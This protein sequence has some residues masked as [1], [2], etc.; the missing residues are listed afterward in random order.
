MRHRNA[1][2]ALIAIV[3]VAC[4]GRGTL[5]RTDPTCGPGTHVE[6][7]SCVPDGT[8]DTDSS[9]DTDGGGSSDTDAGG[10]SDTDP[11]TLRYDV[12]DDGVA[13]FTTL[14]DA[15]DAA[16]DG[17]VIT[18]CPGRWY[19]GTLERRDLTIEGIDG[20][21]QTII[22]GSATAAALT[23]VDSTLKVRGLTLTNRSVHSS[24]PTCLSAQGS[25]ISGEDLVLT[26]VQAVTVDSAYLLKLNDTESTWEN[27]RVHDNAMAGTLVV[28]NGGSF[29]L[30]H[31]IFEH[32][33]SPASGGSFSDLSALA[34][35]TVSGEITNNLFYGNVTTG[36]HTDEWFKL[37]AKTG[38]LLLVSNNVFHENTAP[39]TCALATIDQFVDFRNNIVSRNCGPVRGET[40]AASI[41]YTLNFQNA[42]ASQQLTG[43]GNLSDDPLFTDPA[44][45]IFAFPAGRSPA[46]NAG[47]PAAA[48]KDV[49]G[50][51]NDVGAYGGPNGNW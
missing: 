33:T 13:P 35:Y 46:E 6:G 2:C 48:F 37:A 11:A 23:V 42:S 15:I 21:D 43:T 19:R 5:D 25:N 51:R 49:D 47:D 34:A 14:Q 24:V 29:N 30:R 40:A 17:D 16:Q 39:S 31:S 4:E 45:G 26:G 50:S 1:H 8:F 36:S 38:H 9:S 27:L 41:H 22:E 3:T 44:H 20:P 28:V 18:L 32:N 7:K 10:T 12:C